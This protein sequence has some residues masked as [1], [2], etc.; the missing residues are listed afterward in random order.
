MWPPGHRS[1]TLAKGWACLAF[2]SLYRWGISRPA[3][4]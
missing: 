1:L 2:R 4:V 3:C